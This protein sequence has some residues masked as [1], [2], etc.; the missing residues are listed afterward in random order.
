ME[1][2][3]RSPFILSFAEPVTPT[4]TPGTYDREKQ[5]W[6]TPDGHTA[7]ANTNTLATSAPERTDEIDQ[8]EGV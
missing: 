7:T 6:L 4:I 8:G 3:S 1:D 2:L 5:M